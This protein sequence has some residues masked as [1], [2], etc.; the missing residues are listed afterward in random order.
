MMTSRHEAASPA[1]KSI[2]SCL[3]F[4][5]IHHRRRSDNYPRGRARAALNDRDAL[6]NL[7]RN[8]WK[9]L[10]IRNGKSRGKS[11]RYRF[12]NASRIAR[13][14]RTFGERAR[15]IALAIALLQSMT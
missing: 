8:I 1:T 4:I 9:T 5:H 15:D 3:S 10:E 13:K 11:P 2:T 12:R 7:A 6:M 14:F